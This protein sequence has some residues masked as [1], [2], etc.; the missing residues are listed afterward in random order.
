MD[1]LSWFS[2]LLA[3]AIFVFVVFEVLY[4]PGAFQS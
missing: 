1:W 3:L 2:V 4:G